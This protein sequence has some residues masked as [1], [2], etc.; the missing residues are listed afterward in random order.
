MKITHSHARSMARARWGEDP[1]AVSTSRRGVYW[2][3][4]A[5]H[6]GYIVPVTALTFDERV[7]IEKFLNPEYATAIW[8]VAKE[9]IVK[10][11]GPDSFRTIKYNYGSHRAFEI[12]IFFGEEDC[13]WAVIEKFTDIRRPS[14][15]SDPTQTFWDWFDPENPKVRGRLLQEANQ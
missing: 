15:P 12:K 3:D 11:R 8:D 2:F 6:G 5:S 7:A 1:R 14:A 10:F 4:C 13:D 9:R